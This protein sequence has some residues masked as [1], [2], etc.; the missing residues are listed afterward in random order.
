MWQDFCS[1][2]AASDGVLLH[3]GSLTPVQYHPRWVPYIGATE[4]S[5]HLA[6]FMC[7]TPSIAVAAQGETSR[8]VKPQTPNWENWVDG[9][10]RLASKH[11]LSWMRKGTQMLNLWIS[12]ACLSLRAEKWGALMTATALAPSPRD[13]LCSSLDFSNRWCEPQNDWRP[14]GHDWQH[15]S[16]GCSTEG[17]AST[18][19]R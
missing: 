13:A 2:R 16:G 19:D 10:T 17:K 3:F 4:R 9:G 11:S 14:E 15:L 12:F 8:P 1:G 5:L 18:P 7:V 6:M